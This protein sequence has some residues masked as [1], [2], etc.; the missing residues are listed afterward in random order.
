MRGHTSR[1]Q[2]VRGIPWNLGKIIM[3]MSSIFRPTSVRLR[4]PARRLR[5]RAVPASSTLNHYGWEWLSTDTCDEN[6]MDLAHLLAHG[7]TIQPQVGCVLVRDVEDGSAKRRQGEI[8]ACG[9]N[10]FLVSDTQYGKNNHKQGRR[11][12]DCHAEANAVAESA[13]QGLP[14]LGATCYVSMAPCHTCFTLMAAAG[15]GEIVA[16]EPMPHKQE[17]CAEDL[18]I[19]LRVVRCSEIRQ[20]LRSQLVSEHVDRA[21]VAELRDARKLTGAERY[22]ANLERLARAGPLCQRRS[23]EEEKS[24]NSKL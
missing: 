8:I 9:V 17:R 7:S 23:E 2:P 19:A 10:T 1:R 13:L 3:I 18:G 12:P 22:A 21:L 5:I 24:K 16:Y 20:A 15:I 11:K 14:L 4:M 6:Y